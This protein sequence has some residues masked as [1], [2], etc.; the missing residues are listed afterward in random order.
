MGEL[1]IM[2]IST[3]IVESTAAAPTTTTM[4]RSQIMSIDHNLEEGQTKYGHL[5]D[6]L[7]ILKKIYSCNQ[8]S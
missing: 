3:Y 2:I 4:L 1:L 8:K 7:V 6:W 5:G